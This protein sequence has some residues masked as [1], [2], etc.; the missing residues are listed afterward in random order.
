[1]LCL[2]C[3]QEEE[4]DWHALFSCDAI[5]Q[6]WHSAGLEDVLVPRIQQGTDAKAVIHAFC[7]G[8]DKVTAGLYATVA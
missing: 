1:L 7:A 2:L 4:D 3:N 6:A 5:R 8:E